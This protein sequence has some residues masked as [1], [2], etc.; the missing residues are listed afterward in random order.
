MVRVRT[1]QLAARLLASADTK[2]ME[3]SLY[4]TT[5]IVSSRLLKKSQRTY[6]KK[7]YLKKR[8]YFKKACRSVFEL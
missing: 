1:S 4:H 8:T 7:A 5:N 3:K 6:L 2:Q